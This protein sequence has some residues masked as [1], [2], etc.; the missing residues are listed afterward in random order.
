MAKPF[1]FEL[2]QELY[3]KSGDSITFDLCT[4][5][6]LTTSAKQISFT[7]FLPK[8]MN[9]VTPSI[10]SGSLNVRATNGSYLVLNQSVIA[11]NNISVKKV[12]NIL[13]VHLIYDEAF[14]NATNNTPVGVQISNLKIDFE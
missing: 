7:I 1:N 6:Y 2:K 3:Y 10:S 9:N 4:A 12:D 8:R 11:N 14:A 5:G 13:T